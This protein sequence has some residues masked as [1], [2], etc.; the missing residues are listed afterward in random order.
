MAKTKKVSII[1]DMISNDKKQTYIRPKKLLLSRFIVNNLKNAPSLT[2][3]CRYL[4]KQDEHL[5]HI[6]LKF[7]VS[8]LSILS[9]KN[10]CTS[11][12]KLVVSSFIKDNYSHC[13]YRV[14]HRNVDKLKLNYP[15]YYK[16]KRNKFLIDRMEI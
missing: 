16:D 10:N 12:K 2:E 1:G 6:V 7:E 4:C 3:H 9:Q 11:A 15:T 14:I 8:I 13:L 5:Y